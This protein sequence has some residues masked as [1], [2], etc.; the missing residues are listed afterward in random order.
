MG[1]RRTRLS[2]SL[3]LDV[4]TRWC[5]CPVD[6]LEGDD[7]TQ[8]GSSS[9]VSRELPGDF[10]CCQFSTLKARSQFDQRTVGPIQEPKPI[11]LAGDASDFPT[12]GL[13]SPQL[14]CVF[15]SQLSLK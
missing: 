6:D 10:L 1:G 7:L 4:A 13:E 8:S 14:L 11:S 15:C 9:R 5:C 2:D 3:P 12:G